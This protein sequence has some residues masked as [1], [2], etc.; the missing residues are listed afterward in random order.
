MIE[1]EAKAANASANAPRIGRADCVS[2]ND[3]LA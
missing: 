3:L 2:S 1:G